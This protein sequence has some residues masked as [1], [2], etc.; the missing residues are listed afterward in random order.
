M[1]GAQLAGTI[2]DLCR[3]KPELD[4]SLTAALTKWLKDR[5][6]RVSTLEDFRRAAGEGHA[7]LVRIYLSTFAASDIQKIAKKFD[8]HHRE[9]LG[10][11]ADGQRAHILALIRRECD[12]VQRPSG[13]QPPMPIDEVLGLRD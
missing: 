3:T 2:A 10:L 9:L 12:P 4:G 11:T 5:L 6:G 13:R 1:T 7:D 8:P